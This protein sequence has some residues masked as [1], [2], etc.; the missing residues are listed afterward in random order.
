M[1]SLQREFGDRV[2][3]CSSAD[4][5]RLD[6]DGWKDSIKPRYP[7]Q[8]LYSNGH[9]ILDTGMTREQSSYFGGGTFY[10]EPFRH[11]MAALESADLI[12]AT[13]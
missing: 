1:A 12:I 4:N 11:M 7:F 10:E 5:Q 9:I 6:V 2:K 3:C 8:I 13:H